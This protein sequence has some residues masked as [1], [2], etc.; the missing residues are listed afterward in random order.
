MKGKFEQLWPDGDLRKQKFFKKVPGP[1]RCRATPTEHKVY[2]GKDG[3][4]HS[5]CESCQKC[6]SSLFP[7]ALIVAERRRLCPGCVTTTD[8]FQYE[9]REG[10][11]YFMCSS[12]GLESTAG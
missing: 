7:T 3:T 9:S 10:H 2:F 12:C 11:H 6:V 1:C 5:A 4:L 8:Q